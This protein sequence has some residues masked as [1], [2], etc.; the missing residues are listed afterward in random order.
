[1]RLEGKKIILGIT[2]SI[3]AYKAVVLLRLLI[4]E[5]AEVQVVITP[6]GKEFITPVTLAAISGKPVISQFFG[7]D[8][9]TWHSHIDLGLWADLM[10]IAPATA[11]TIGKMAGGIADNILLTTYI[12]AKCPVLTAPVMDSGMFMHPSTTQN[13]ATLKKFGNIIIEPAEG[14][15]ASGLKGKGRM[16]EPE[17]ILEELIK[18]FEKKNF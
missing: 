8:D 11:N 15:L 3:A 6:S 18:F 12:S 16:Q 5:G 7:S 14:Q 1:M 13:I 9:G 4:K 2:G 17:I 10:L